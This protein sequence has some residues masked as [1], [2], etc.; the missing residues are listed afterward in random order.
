MRLF[1]QHPAVTVSLRLLLLLILERWLSDMGSLPTR[2]ALKS[3][4]NIPTA[5]AGSSALQ[6]NMV[7]DFAGWTVLN[8]AQAIAEFVG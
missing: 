6:I 1:S 8:N 5:A 7:A 3:W 2:G 4:P